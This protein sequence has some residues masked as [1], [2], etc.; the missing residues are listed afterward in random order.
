MGSDF[1]PTEDTVSAFLDLLV[2]PLLPSLSSLAR[3]EAP[4]SAQEESVAKQVQAVV[5][6]YD[7]YHRKCNPEL[8][9]LD[10]VSFCKLAV[11]LKPSLL[12][13]MESVKKDKDSELD[14]HEMKLSLTDKMI[15]E[16]CD[17]SK[18]LETSK[19][20]DVAEWP[21]PKVAVFL[22]DSSKEYCI[23][24]HS[25]ITQ[26]VWSV[27]EKDCSA[28]DKAPSKKKRI[29]KKPLKE[30]R[31]DET[32]F[33][34]LAFAAV[35]DAC[36]CSQN[37]LEILESHIVYS[38]SK[39]KTAVRFYIMQSKRTK[40]EDNY[41]PIR[42]VLDSLQGPLVTKDACIWATTSVV[43]YF[44]LLPYAE[45]LSDWFSGEPTLEAG[46]EQENGEQLPSDSNGEDNERERSQKVASLPND[47]SDPCKMPN[48]EDPE[49]GY[50]NSSTVTKA[51]SSE[52]VEAEQEISVTPV[53]TSLQNDGGLEIENQSKEAPSRILRS[54][55]STVAKTATSDKVE[56]DQEISVTPVNT[57]VQDDVRLV[58]ENQSKGSPSRILRSGMKSEKMKAADKKVES[59]ETAVYSKRRKTLKKDTVG[60]NSGCK[61]SK[62]DAIAECSIQKDNEVSVSGMSNNMEIDEPVSSVD[63]SM[64]GKNKSCC[65]ED[66]VPN[67]LKAIVLSQNCPPSPTTDI[68]TK[69]EIVS[70]LQST[71][72]KNEENRNAQVR[73][74]TSCHNG[75]QEEIVATFQ[76]THEQNGENNNAR[77]KAISSCQDGVN[78][79]IP[80]G[81]N[82][83]DLEKTN[84][85]VSLRETLLSQTALKVLYRKRDKLSYQR[86]SIED[87]IALCNSNIEAILNGKI[88]TGSEDN[89]GV[90]LDSIIEACNFETLSGG[91]SDHERM[92][93]HSQDQ[94]TRNYLK[95]KRLSEANL[96]LQNPCQE[97]DDICHENCWVIPTYNITISDGGFRAAVIVKGVEFEC[98]STGGTR[99]TPVEARESAASLALTK[100]RNM[101]STS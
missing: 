19:A 95:R 75:M 2:D 23:L 72:T 100:L 1:G 35:K 40:D 86:R 80:Y 91:V 73:A 56:T 88:C 44:H 50:S 30:S 3:N 18:T 77:V 68:V 42:D 74:A 9:F 8:E 62:A 70:A 99:N 58:V 14:E 21:I 16:A 98:S 71:H 38:L 34:Q 49:A 37:E 33:R 76:S 31:N 13:Y 5:L 53:I 36:G 46:S 60:D 51:N 24:L 22:V 32:V 29:T 93:R 81:S 10:H 27:I 69:E 15:M 64:D 65:S 59:V 52:K 54:Y 87:E 101:A 85:V 41:V 63:C 6:L 20:A 94:N 96:V 4:S 66:H 26:G 28:E 79:L 43:E 83:R 48:K 92:Y 61:L 82:F 39:A 90:K 7:Y 67:E 78:A 12:P 97:L 17:I 11:V 84:K 45:I 25:S 47:V 55:S 57:K 89:L